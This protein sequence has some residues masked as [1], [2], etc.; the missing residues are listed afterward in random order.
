MFE[1]GLKIREKKAKKEIGWLS[2]R[3]ENRNKCA[4]D[5]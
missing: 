2:L 3:K 1:G 4:E 5:Y